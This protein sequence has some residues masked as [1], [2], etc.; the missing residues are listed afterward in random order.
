MIQMRNESRPYTVVSRDADADRNGYRM[1]KTI[2]AVCPFCDEHVK[3]FVWSLHGGGKLCK[4][5]AKFG[6]GG[7]AQKVVEQRT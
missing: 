7:Q 5:G 3:I 6:G 1:Q 4:C 2:T